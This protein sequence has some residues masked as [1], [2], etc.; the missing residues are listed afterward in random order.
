MMLVDEKALPKGLG[1]SSDVQPVTGSPKRFSDVVG[2]D[3]AKEDLMDIV[4][5]LRQ[6]KTFTWLGGKLP[7]G[8]LLTGP[9]GT[10]KTLLRARS[11]VRRACPSFTCPA[12][13][14]RRSLS[15]SARRG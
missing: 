5:Y 12:P 13:S 11:P 10:G 3:E 14:L 9:P 4:E 6:P 8:C 1:L 2:V 15:A 7:K